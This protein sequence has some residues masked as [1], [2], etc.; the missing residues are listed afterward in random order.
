MI[1]F[2]RG[3]GAKKAMKI[4]V[5]ANCKVITSCQ[6]GLGPKYPSPENIHKTLKSYEDGIAIKWSKETRDLFEHRW[7]FRI[8]GDNQFQHTL[9]VLSGGFIEYRGKI[10][11]IP[12]L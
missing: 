12:E 1:H 8:E 7:K 10:Y 4:G 2:E 5:V 3:I 11:E 6:G 9:A